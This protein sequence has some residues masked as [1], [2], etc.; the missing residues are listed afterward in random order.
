M[1]IIIN[2][3]KLFATVALKENIMRVKASVLLL[4]IMIFLAGCGSIKQDSLDNKIS[5]C[6][7]SVVVDAIRNLE[8][9]WKVLY[10]EWY[11]EVISISD[12]IE[13]A[14]IQVK[15][16]KTEIM[17]GGGPDIFVLSC[18]DPW[19]DE[20]VHL[21][22]NPE[23]MMESEVFL[24]LDDYIAS[25]QYMDY[26]HLN[27]VIM[28][29]GKSSE[30]QMLMPICYQYGAFGFETDDMSWPNSWEAVIENA[31]SYETD[32]IYNYY[33][34]SFYSLFEPIADYANKALV[35]PEEEMLSCAQKTRELI[36]QMNNVD[37]E[38]D[39]YLLKSEGT[40][41]VAHHTALTTNDATYF[42]GYPNISG[43]ITASVKSYAA[44][45]RNSKNPEMAF[46]FID[47]LFSDEIMSGNGIKIDD[48]WYGKQ[49]GFMLYGACQTTNT[50]IYETLYDE[51]SSHGF[52]EMI[53]LEERIDN[54]RFYSD[55]DV[56]IQNMF[57]EILKTKDE[58]QQ[59]KI[60][61]D[62][63]AALQMKLQE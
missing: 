21:F 60:V 58:E 59:K 8:N 30:G 24:P 43:G 46:S 63:Y 52:Q 49:I 33:A 7:D 16:I 32:L 55:F 14:E 18:V 25:A 56:D 28:N 2:F 47:L 45:N 19:S 57:M 61:E 29:A 51:F 5:V 11:I 4:V 41:P 6:V 9:T 35:V 53:K 13:M 31:P 36:I 26:T 42:Y 27:P 62:T 40:F 44:L 22:T 15:S 38:M 50:Y 20:E 37:M 39:T 12:D 54:V 10:P 48:I 3:M 23:K 34:V 1:A 17:A